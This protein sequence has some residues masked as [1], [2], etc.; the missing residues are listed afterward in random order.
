MRKLLI[1]ILV[2]SFAFVPTAAAGPTSPGSEDE[3]SGIICDMVLGPDSCSRWPIYVI[4]EY[5]GIP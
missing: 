2:A 5:L 4:E 1:C 3:S